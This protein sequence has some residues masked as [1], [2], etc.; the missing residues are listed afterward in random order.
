MDDATG[1]SPDLS[2]INIHLSDGVDDDVRLHVESGGDGDVLSSDGVLDAASDSVGDDVLLD[3]GSASP[4][5][6]LQWDHSADIYTANTSGSV[7]KASANVHSLAIG[8][9]RKIASLN[10]R[11]SAIKKAR[12]TTLAEKSANVKLACAYEL[13]D[14][15]L[16]SIPKKQRL[17]LEELIKDCKA[18]KGDYSI[19]FNVA[20]SSQ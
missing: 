12:A 19:N 3:E 13:M 17:L 18:G 1:L 20:S 4:S 15:I 8:K 16:S 5:T 2:N 9:T 6:D 14:Y 7:V 11:S 10:V